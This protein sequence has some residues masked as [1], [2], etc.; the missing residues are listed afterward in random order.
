MAKA[1]RMSVHKRAMPLLDILSPQPNQG[2]D[3]ESN[4]C[5]KST[6]QVLEQN[7]SKG[8]LRLLAAEKCQKKKRSLVFM[9]LNSL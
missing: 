7:E 3:H 1:K 2:H 8:Q 5:H 6:Y 4:V 9:V